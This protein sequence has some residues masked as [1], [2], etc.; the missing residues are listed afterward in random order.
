MEMILM[1]EK[2]DV[3]PTMVKKEDLGLWEEKEVEG[4]SYIMHNFKN[5]FGFDP[6]VTTKV[7]CGE[8]EME[9]LD[10]AWHCKWA[11]LGPTGIFIPKFLTKILVH[12]SSWRVGVLQRCSHILQ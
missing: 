2:A 8:L 6:L 11:M 1:D 7:Y 9:C 3:I 10:R 4:K 12:T 5:D